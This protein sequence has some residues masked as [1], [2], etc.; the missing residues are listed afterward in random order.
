MAVE[1]GYAQ[2]G[3]V[4][5]IQFAREPQIG[6][7]K[8]RMM[9]FLSAAQAC[10]LHSDLT[11][12]TTRQLLAS[13]LGPVEVIVAG[14][15]SHALFKQCQSLGV[16]AVRQQCGA[17]LGQRMY[18]SLRDALTRYQSVILVGSDCPGIDTAY[19]SKAVQAL[20]RST[21][22]IGPATD[23]GYVLIGARAIDEAIFRGIS[24]GSDQVY[25]STVNVLQTVCVD[26]EALPCLSD[27]DRPEDLTVWETVNGGA[28][29][30]DT[31]G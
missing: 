26:W 31:P 25:A 14:D 21:V 22:V 13:A 9:P 17:D 3:E 10:R 4:L 12:W 5:L 16:K 6:R 19:L 23:G 24:W 30:P 20:Q 15:T 28:K 2:R 8:T 1:P 7:V 29:I 18:N 11:L 27:I